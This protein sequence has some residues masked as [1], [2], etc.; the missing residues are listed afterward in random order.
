MSSSSSSLRVRTRTRVRVCAGGPRERAAPR[1]ARCAGRAAPGALRRARCVRACRRGSCPH[2]PSIESSRRSARAHLTTSTSSYSKSSSDS[3]PSPGAAGAAACCSAAC[4]AAG[5]AAAALPPLPARA[6]SV[7]IRGAGYSLLR[8]RGLVAS[9]S[10]GAVVNAA[11]SAPE[12]NA[13]VGRAR[14]KAIQET[15]RNGC[16]TPGPSRLARGGPRFWGSAPLPRPGP[17]AS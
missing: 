14:E 10:W 12:T 4:G 9:S 6:A 8:A 15:Q 13:T 3:P 7:A 2:V 17:P 16:P 5:A 11:V 1:R